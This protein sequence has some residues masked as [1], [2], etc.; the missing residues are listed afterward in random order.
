VQRTLFLKEKL[1]QEFIELK[2]WTWLCSFM[3]VQVNAVGP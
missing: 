2:G 1:T 3:K